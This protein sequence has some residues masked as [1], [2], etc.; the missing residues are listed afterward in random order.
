MNN[1]KLSPS[2]LVMVAGSSKGTQDKYFDNNYWY[3]SDSKGYEG[4]SEYLVSKVLSCSNAENYVEYE[5]CSINGKN[6]CRSLNFLKPGETFMSFQRLYDIYNGGSLSETIIPLNDVSERVSFVKNFIKDVTGLDVS[7]YLSKILT[8]D[9][10]TLNTDRH[11]N[12]LGVII[13][14]DTGECKEA[15]IFDNGAALLSNFAQF[16]PY[17]SI[18]E[19]IDKAY[20]M[21]FSSSFGLQVKE[22]G[23]GLALD[24]RKLN[25]ILDN[26]PNS[27]ALNVL[28]LQIERFK[29]IIPDINFDIGHEEE[30]EYDND[31]FDIGDE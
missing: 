17:C 10:L 22:C 2:A 30:C 3:K 25:S 6:G 1:Y 21:P 4:L 11:F 16:E 9:M 8:L 29:D 18:E 24:Y 23:I 13:N 15:P 7:N 12:N 28:K 19:N 5:R 14:P 26:E 31:D 27:R 20:A